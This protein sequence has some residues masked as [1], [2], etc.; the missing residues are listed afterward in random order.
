MLKSPNKPL[1]MRFH[2]RPQN[3][4]DAGLVAFALGFKPREY[5]TIDAQGDGVFGLGYHDLGVFPE[6]FIGGLGIGV[7]YRCFIN[8]CL[9][10]SRDPIP[11]C[12][13][14]VGDVIGTVVRVG[15]NR[16]GYLT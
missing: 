13:C 5:V 3:G 4:V 11:I 7:R 1:T 16:H 15:G 6:C 8:L 9:G 12:L 2:I 14:V 10:H